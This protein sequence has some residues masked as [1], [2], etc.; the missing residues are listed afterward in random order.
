M[1][2]GN[3]FI[4]HYDQH[5]HFSQKSTS[6]GEE[7]LCLIVAF[8][9]ASS[10]RSY[11]LHAAV[12]QNGTNLFLRNKYLNTNTNLVPYQNVNKHSRNSS[13]APDMILM[14][15]YVTNAKSHTKH[16]PKQLLVRSL[17]RDVTEAI[18]ETEINKEAK[19]LFVIK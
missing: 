6:I 12:F 1:Y 5:H 15:I 17:A 4:N 14:K 19:C 7:S 11:F 2:H 8:T 9:R 13:P 18:L 16:R 10:H 3:C